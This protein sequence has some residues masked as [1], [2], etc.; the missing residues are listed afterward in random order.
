MRRAQALLA[1]LSLGAIFLSG[2]LGERIETAPGANATYPPG[3]GEH[4]DGSA[5]T[6]PSLGPPD[7]VLEAH[8]GMPEKDFQLHPDPVRVPVGSV[9]ELRI[10]NAGSSAHTF[11][12]HEYDVDTGMMSPGEE[13]T[14]AFRADKAG[15]FEIMCDVS[16]H[17]Q[18]GMKA[19]LEVA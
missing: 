6:A 4:H 1:A 17:Y 15:S 8:A 16:G 10:G 11:T 12:I 14:L 19:T 9:V 7:L 5:P 2:C 13:R 3:H 18:A